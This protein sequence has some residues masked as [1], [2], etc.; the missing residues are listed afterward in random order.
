MTTTKLPMAVSFILSDLK[1]LGQ[2]A[3]AMQKLSH[4][5]TP[6]QTYV[7]RAAEDER[8][9]FDMRVA[10][11]I[12]RMDAEYRSDESTRQGLFLYQFEVL[13]RNYLE[14][15]LGLTAIAAD[16]VFDDDWREWI[17]TV[18]RQVGIVDLADLLYVRSEY[19]LQRQSATGRAPELTGKPVLFGAKE[20]RIAMAHHRKDPLF[21]FAALQRHLGYPQVPRQKRVDQTIELVPQLM[22]RMERLE[23]RLKLCEEEQRSGGIDLTRFYVDETT[24]ERPP[25]GST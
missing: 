18:R 5:F 2:F 19:Y 3:P 22:R 25:G 12:L 20:G 9:R 17:L 7:V 6:F 23:S 4:Y 16:P 8:G 11:E 13:C 1:H 21:L 24:G 14:Y 10:F 15:D